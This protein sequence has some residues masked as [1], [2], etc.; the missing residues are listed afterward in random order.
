MI[1]PDVRMFYF[2]LLFSYAMWLLQWSLLFSYQAYFGKPAR[3]QKIPT[4]RAESKRDRTKQVC[5][6]IFESAVASNGAPD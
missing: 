1:F 6:D 3:F 5:L 2:W 4:I